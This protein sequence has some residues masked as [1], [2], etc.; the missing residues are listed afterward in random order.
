MKVLF[1]LVIIVMLAFPFRSSAQTPITFK[2]AYSAEDEA[3]ITNYKI[4][5]DGIGNDYL[6]LSPSKELREIGYLETEDTVEH[7]YFI[8]AENKEENLES[9]GSVFA[10]FRPEKQPVPNTPKQLTIEI[11]PITVIVE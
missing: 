10:W 1:F 3:K 7:V 5:R 2:W 8:S 4:F 11:P 9:V 6:I